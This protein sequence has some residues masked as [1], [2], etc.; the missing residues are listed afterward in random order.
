[1]IPSNL[2][3]LYDDTFLNLISL[4]MELIKDNVKPFDIKNVNSYT[5][6]L[7]DET[8]YLKVVL[9]SKY[10]DIIKN[11]ISMSALSIVYNVYLSNDI[12]KELIIYYFLL[13]GFKYGSKI[14]YL[15]NLKCVNSALKLNR[16]VGSEAHKLKGFLRFKELPNGSLYAQISPTN[17]VL[18][19]LCNHFK[20]R[21]ANESWLIKDESRNLIGIYQNNHYVIVTSNINLDT[22]ANT[23]K[24]KEFE[25]MWISFFKTVSINERTNKKCQMNFMPKKYWQYLIEM[26]DQFETSNKW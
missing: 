8:L 9:D 10:Y 18:E 26:E 24:E 7:V 16:Y 25:D 21:L 11:R 20:T 17:N 1:M 12:H 22:I 4:I 5:P 14:I 6:N 15:R 19:I 13:N 3:Y 2:I 23:K